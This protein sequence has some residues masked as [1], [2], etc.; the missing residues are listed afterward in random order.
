M[1]HETVVRGAQKANSIF[2]KVENLI[3]FETHSHGVCYQYFSKSQGFVI[4]TSVKS[5][6]FCM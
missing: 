2:L 6:S 5:Q 4:N 1:P 3:Y